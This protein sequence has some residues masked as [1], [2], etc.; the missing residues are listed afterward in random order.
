MRKFLPKEHIPAQSSENVEKR[1]R[2]AAFDT[3]AL[4][5]FWL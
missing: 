1:G 2:C 5:Q 3:F 4:L